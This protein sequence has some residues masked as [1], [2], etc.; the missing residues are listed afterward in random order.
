MQELELAGGGSGRVVGVNGIAITECAI[1]SERIR[2]T[3]TSPFAWT[4]KPVVVFRRAVAGRKYRVVVNGADLGAYEEKATPREYW[5]PLQWPSKTAWR[6]GR[7]PLIVL[8]ATKRIRALVSNTADKYKAPINTKDG[9]PLSEMPGWN[10]T[11]CTPGLIPGTR[12]DRQPD[13]QR[14]GR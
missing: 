1:A 14:Q 4:G 3:M 7:I 2:L 6:L 8:G 5:F 11:G 10:M 12:A 9:A 13:R